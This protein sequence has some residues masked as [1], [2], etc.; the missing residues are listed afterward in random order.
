MLGRGEERLISGLA[1]ARGAVDQLKRVV[2]GEDADVAEG[3]EVEEV[4]ITGDDE[5]RL[6]GER[7]GE[8]VIVVGIARGGFERRG[9]DDRARARNPASIS[10]GELP[11]RVMRAANFSRESTSS[12]SARS[13]GLVWSVMRPSRAAVSTAAGGPPQRKAETTVLVS[14]TTRT[15]GAGRGDLGVDLFFGE[16][17]EA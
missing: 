15:V 17:L 9:P 13:T 16:R 10:R 12:S 5:D 4:A 14:A 3:T 1:S 11:M 8:H 6:G 2:R 7:T